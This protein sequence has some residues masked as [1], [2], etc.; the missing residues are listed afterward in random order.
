M[1][2]ILR[3][4]SVLWYFLKSFLV[5]HRIFLDFLA[6]V[7]YWHHPV[8][9]KRNSRTTFL[10]FAEELGSHPL[11]HGLEYQFQIYDHIFANPQCIC[12]KCITLRALWTLLVDY[13]ACLN[14]LEILLLLKHLSKYEVNVLWVLITVHNSLSK[15][16]CIL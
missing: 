8:S 10:A 1:I 7:T 9:I 3:V 6:T 13:T 15:K 16:K 12:L 4:S 14:S 11:I 5:I 2:E